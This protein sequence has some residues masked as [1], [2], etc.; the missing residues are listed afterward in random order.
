M[1]AMSDKMFVEDVDQPWLVYTAWL[2]LNPSP[3]KLIENG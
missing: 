3:K 1:F 2:L